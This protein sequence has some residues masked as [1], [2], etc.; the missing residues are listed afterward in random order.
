MLKSRRFYAASLAMLAC[1][2][3][4]RH[5][6][7]SDEKG[8]KMGAV[9]IAVKDYDQWRPVFDRVKPLRDKAGITNARVYRDTENKN[10]LLVWNEISDVTSAREGI[11]GPEIRSDSETIN[12]VVF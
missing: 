3:M 10:E 1:A 2:G 12:C 5:P 9:Q 11:T 6:F 8:S 7:R 4:N